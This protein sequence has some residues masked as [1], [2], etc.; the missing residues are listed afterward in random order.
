MLAG[1]LKSVSS[2]VRLAVALIATL[3]LSHFAPEIFSL[4]AHSSEAE[5]LTTFFSIALIFVLS[6]GI[7]YVAQGTPLPNFVIAIFFG[8]AAKPLLLPVVESHGAMG[9]LVGFGAT[10]IL[11][12]GGLETPLKN[13]LRLFGKIFALSFIGLALTALLFS[14]SLSALGNFSTVGVSVTAAILLGALLAS[15]DPA[16]IIPVLKHLRFKNPTTKDL[17][18]SE[19]AVTDVTG[20]IL[21]LAFLTLAAAGALDG[22]VAQGYAKIFSL[23]T[24]TALLHQLVFGVV[25][26][27]LGFGLLHVLTRFKEQHDRE[28]EADS[29]FF[30]FI[31]LIIFTLAIAFGGSGYLAAFLAGLL[32]KLTEGL[33]ETERFFNHT[34]DGFFKPTIFLMLGALVEPSS[35]ITYAPLGLAAAAVF[36]FVIRPLSVFV[37]LAPFMAFGRDKVNWR[38]MLFVS[39]VRETGAIPAVLLVTVAALNLEGLDGLVPVGMIVILA[40]LII[41]PPLTPLIAT[42]LKVATPIPLARHAVASGKDSTV[43]LGTRGDTWQQRLP[44]VAEWAYTHH[45]PHIVLLV[46]LEYKHTPE[47]AKE[48]ERAAKAFMEQLNAKNERKGLPAQDFSVM[49]SEGLLQEKIDH[50]SRT[51]ENVVAIFVGR[52]MLDFQLEE[53]KKLSV[54]LFFMP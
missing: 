41:E 34:I 44:F 29:A 13:F 20:T 15:T 47:A 9:A 33:K 39:F 18:I 17:V 4:F 50:I 54:P 40:T 12:G 51:E 14:L 25:F 52:K 11:F 42:W 48:V 10:L 53:I 38:D 2:Y 22:T 7:F 49:L 31:P 6:F 8:L 28:Y 21:T 30:L 35:L 36:M 1:T 27:L 46:C 19:S 23:D 16:A 43:V 3:G 5:L 26:G 32:F 37:S 24:A 45:V